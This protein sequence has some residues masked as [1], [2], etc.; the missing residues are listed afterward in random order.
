M[1][2]ESKGQAERKRNAEATGFSG[3]DCGRRHIERS[4]SVGLEPRGDL[5]TAA[6]RH[7]DRSALRE[8]ERNT[9]QL[10]EAVDLRYNLE[11]TL[12]V[13][14]RAGYNTADFAAESK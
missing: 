7:N 5:R 4:R 14:I 11:S 13:E 6:D 8:A 9:E 1:R 12:K 3:R 10:T 2:K